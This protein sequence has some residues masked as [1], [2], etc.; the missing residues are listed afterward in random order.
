MECESRKAAR[1]ATFTCCWWVVRDTTSIFKES[2]VDHW[3]AGRGWF[4]GKAAL[5]L[6]MHTCAGKN[7]RGFRWS[8][9]ICV[10]SNAQC[11]HELL[12]LWVTV[13]GLSSYFWYYLWDLKQVQKCVSQRG[14]LQLKIL[15]SLPHSLFPSLCVLGSSTYLT[16][17]SSNFTSSFHTFSWALHKKAPPDTKNM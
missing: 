16:L 9:N 8:R 11:L 7:S 14:V 12:Q 17:F 4:L 1:T 13:P 10:F 3:T 2:R 5:D 6:I 15:I